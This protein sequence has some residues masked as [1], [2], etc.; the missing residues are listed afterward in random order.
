MGGTDGITGEIQVSSGGATNGKSGDVLVASGGSSDGNAGTIRVTVGTASTGVGGDLILSSGSSADNR[1]GKVDIKSGYGSTKSSGD[2]LLHTANAGTGGITGKIVM[3]SGVSTQGNS[4]ALY[5]GSGTA[6]SGRAGSIFVTVGSGNSGSGG[7]LTLSSG[8]TTHSTKVGGSVY[9]GSGTGTT[10]G[11][12]QMNVGA[13]G[14]YELYGRT[15]GTTDPALRFTGADDLY[16]GGVSISNAPVDNLDLYS[17]ST[18][19]LEATDTL[20]LKSEVINV[21]ANV[22][23]TKEVNVHALGGVHITGGLT[24]FSG[25][26]WVQGSGAG[27]VSALI[28]TNGI[29]TSDERL[30]TDIVPL[31]NPLSKVSKLRGVYFSWVQHVLPEIVDEIQG[32]KYLGVDYP[33]LIPLLIEAN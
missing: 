33:A 21:L 1:G 5:I 23:T 28:S 15:S 16:V 3:S 6:A 31:P 7:D 22:G 11:K 10:Q 2:M 18:I 20:E 32:G 13:T 27:S 9:I 30:K 4:G 24:I 12:I 8:D 19:N 29:T 14:T 17:T 25:G 26:L